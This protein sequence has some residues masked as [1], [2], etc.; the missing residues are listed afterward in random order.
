MPENEDEHRS[1]SGL[2]SYYHRFVAGFPDI[3]APITR[4]LC[5]MVPFEWSARCS[6][7]FEKLREA[8]CS[9]PI[10]KLPDLEADAGQFMLDTDASDNAIGAVLSQIDSDGLERV[11]TYESRTLN[12]PEKNYCTTR[13]EMLALVHFVKKYRHYLLG[14][15][16]TVRTDHQSLMW[17]Q[18]FKDPEGQVARWQE[19]LQE[20]DFSCIHREGRKHMN[21]DALSC[22]PSRNHG[23]CPSCTHY[24]TQVSLA[25]DTSQ[26]WA[27]VSTCNDDNGIIYRKLVS[28]ESKPNSREVEGLSWETRCMWAMWS[29]LVLTDGVIYFQYDDRSPKRIVV[30]N[31]LTKSVVDRLHSELGHAVMAKV[32]SA[33]R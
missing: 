28:G 6:E 11:I 4:L 16:F 33:C 20:Y 14:R 25:E 19:Y 24:V 2:A 18:N 9:T 3:A 27:N 31:S 21:A 32:K 23:S 8:L 1:S 30:P 7:A 10:L 22:R 5:K 17:L 12:N 29:Y 15:H 26:W 13:K